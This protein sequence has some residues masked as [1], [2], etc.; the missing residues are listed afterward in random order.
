MIWTDETI[1]QF[2]KENTI[3][4]LGICRKYALVYEDY[5]RKI[6]SENNEIEK[7]N[8][9]YAGKGKAPVLLV[10]AAL[11]VIVFLVLSK[12]AHS[13]VLALI[14]TVGVSA[15]YYGVIRRTLESVV[16]KIMM[17][18]LESKLQTEIQPHEQQIAQI[19]EE[20]RNFANSEEMESLLRFL[21]AQYFSS[22]IITYLLNLFQTRRATTLAEAL[23]AYE[24]DAHNRR[25]ENAANISAAANVSA[26]QAQW[27]QLDAIHQQTDEMRA[28]F[29]NVSDEQRRARSAINNLADEQRRTTSAVQ[30][31]AR[32][33]RRTANAASSAAV[34]ANRAANAAE[35][36][37]ESSAHTSNLLSEFLNR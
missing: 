33:Q 28:G 36:S 2:T 1:N 10:G 11:A 25:L 15:A 4:A 22:Q 29:K 9:K 27:Q 26:A 37:A 3:E 23:N 5:D 6:A 34:A 18:R 19:K 13:T 7:I 24:Q 14:F 30:G 16:T 20:Q 32:E 21:P 12:L 8:V 17:K 31:L 35:R